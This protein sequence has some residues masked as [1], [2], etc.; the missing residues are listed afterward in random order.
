MYKLIADKDT[1]EIVMINFVEKVCFIP[2]EPV[3]LDYIKFKKDVSE[4]AELQDADGVT[5]TPEQVQEFI[6][7][8]P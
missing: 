5:M 3:N 4:G 1:Q 2:F 7:T 8:L 6:E